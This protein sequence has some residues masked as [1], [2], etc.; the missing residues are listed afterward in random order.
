MRFNLSLY[1]PLIAVL[2]FA[3]VPC[4]VNDSV[5]AQEKD[6]GKPSSDTEGDAK[7]AADDKQEDAVLRGKIVVN[8]ASSKSWDGHELSIEFSEIEAKLRERVLLLPPPYPAEAAKW[9][10]A[11]VIEWEQGFIETAA[12]KKFIADRKELIENGHAFDIKFEKDGSFVVYDVPAGVYGIQGRVDKAIGGTN[13]G[14]EVYGQLEVLADVDEIALPPLEVEV[15]PLLTVKQTA[16]PI[17]VKT[18][19][20][21]DTMTLDTFGD[22]LLF[23][24]FWTALSPTSTAEQ[25]LVQEMYMGLNDKYKVRLLSINIDQDRKKSLRFIVDQELLHGSHGFTN[26]IDHPTIF[27]YGVRSFPS[28]WLIGKDDTI[29]MSQFEIGQA[30]RLKPDL[31]TIIVDRIEGK[32]VPASAEKDK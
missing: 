14:F 9:K 17:S 10:P 2:M 23:V 15:T 1:R 24:N 12:G 27:N 25:K 5:Q 8:S 21:D 18:D 6:S 30:M 3:L 13:Y 19:E 11:Q 7:A 22:E 28:F 26:G 16:P 32:D 31:K 4:V 20:G 29:L